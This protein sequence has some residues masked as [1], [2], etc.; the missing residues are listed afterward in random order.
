MITH[1]GYDRV[2]MG[3]SLRRGGVSKAIA[4]T[5]LVILAF[6][7]LIHLVVFTS[8]PPDNFKDPAK[9]PL[10]SYGLF[11]P[12]LIGAW[13]IWRSPV[14][15]QIFCRNYDTTATPRDAKGVSRCLRRAGQAST[16]IRR[17]SVEPPPS[18]RAR[19]K[20]PCPHIWCSCPE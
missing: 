4:A 16:E 14:V 3:S 8:M 7:T 18:A 9:V 20:R 17:Y 10:H 15:G 1:S 5:L 19:A 2:L 12:I 11:I 13:L 6:T